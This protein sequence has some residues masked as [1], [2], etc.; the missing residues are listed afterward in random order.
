VSE[1]PHP[2]EPDAPEQPVP[3]WEVEARLATSQD[4]LLRALADLDNQRKRFARELEREVAA[5]RDRDLLAWLDVADS[6]ER[7]L[8]AFA[9]RDDEPG[10][11]GLAALAEQIREVLRRL[12]VERIPAVGEPFDPERHEAVATSPAGELPDGLVA[13]EARP[14]Y[15]IDGRVLRPAQVV[16]ARAPADA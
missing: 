11:G 2:A 16:V 9:G 5:A 15:S 4:R 13:G 7:G 1:E 3:P 6:A 8:A 12:G 14:G 10:V